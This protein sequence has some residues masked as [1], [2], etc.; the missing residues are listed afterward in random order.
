M[1]QY[2]VIRNW[3]PFPA[4]FPGG[5]DGKRICLQFGR[6]WF[7]PWVGKIPWR[8]ARQH[9]PVFLHEESPWIEEPD[10]LQSMRSQRVRHD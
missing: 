7:H 8:R 3:L 5:S 6:P 9:T 1:I 2:P 10:R 4:G